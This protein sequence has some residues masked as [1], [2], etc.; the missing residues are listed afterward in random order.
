MGWLKRLVGS[1]RAPDRHLSAEDIQRRLVRYAEPARRSDQPT[2][3]GHDAWLQDAV[4]YGAHGKWF[5]ADEAI[6]TTPGD[7]MKIRDIADQM[8]RLAN[9]GRYRIW[10]KTAAEPRH[11][12]IPAEFWADNEID[13]LRL[14]AD[15]NP[16]NA[17]TEGGTRQQPEPYSGLRVSKSATESLWPPA[18]SDP[19]RLFEAAG[20]LTLEPSQA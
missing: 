9:A 19:P 14:L 17:C 18:S 12:Q 13:V 8:R 7:L 2:D 20:R 11:R 10:G 15:G 3:E 16:E 6:R 4:W 5:A 1:G